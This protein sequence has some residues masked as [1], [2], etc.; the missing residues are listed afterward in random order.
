MIKVVVSVYGENQT[1][2]FSQIGVLLNAVF[3]NASPEVM[4][5]DSTSAEVV[6]QFETV[7]DMANLLGENLAAE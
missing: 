6:A 7:A 2:T 1:E 5:V 3:V 4:N